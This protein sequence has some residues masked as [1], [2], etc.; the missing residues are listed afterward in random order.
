MLLL[1]TFKYG[2]L[3]EAENMQVSWQH[4]HYVSA[5]EDKEQNMKVC[6]TP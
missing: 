5:V 3:L 1:P 4:V 6:V 2:H